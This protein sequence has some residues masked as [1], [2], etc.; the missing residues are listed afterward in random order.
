MASYKIAIT[1]G[2]PDGIGLEVIEKALKKIVLPKDVQLLIFKSSKTKI[3]IPQKYSFAQATSL[4]E[5]L[6]L[7]ASVVLISSKD[8]A[9][10]WIEQS[11]RAAKRNQISSLVTAPLSKGLI[12][13]SGLKDIGHTDILKRICGVESAYMGFFGSKFNVILASGHI[14]IDM[15]EK[16][17]S[18]ERLFSVFSVVSSYKKY[19][20][21]A[22]QKLPIGVLGL[23]PHAGDMG[24]LGQFEQRVLIPT[25]KKAKKTLPLEGPLIP[26][27]AFQKQNWKKYSFYIALY[28]DQGLIP[29]KMAHGYGGAHL[30]LGLPIPRSSVDHGT[31]KDIFGKNRANPDSMIDAIK[32]GIRLA[33]GR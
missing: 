6:K 4:Q 3:S 32:W 14:P 29:F 30:T 21:K 26:D 31:A 18:G 20:P 17:L 24:L 10:L 22:K 33:K 19:L 2:D 5:A 28:H 27:V 25:I 12:V 7:R 11:A 16:S 13:T 8:P 23:N 1:S 15:V 9:P